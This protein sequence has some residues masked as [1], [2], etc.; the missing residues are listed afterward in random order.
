M[1]KHFWFSASAEYNPNEI[2]GH[3]FQKRWIVH[4]CLSRKDWLGIL[5]K[6]HSVNYDKWHTVI[7]IYI[8]CD[9]N[10]ML[11][12]T[13]LWLIHYNCKRSELTV[14]AQISQDHIATA[15]HFLISNFGAGKEVF[16]F[17]YIAKKQGESVLIKR[18]HSSKP[19][20]LNKNQELTS[21]LASVIVTSF[22]SCI[23]LMV[24]ESTLFC[25][26]WDG[27]IWFLID[28]WVYSKQA[29]EYFTRSGGPSCQTSFPFLTSHAS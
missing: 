19:V 18:I 26:Q 17:D 1:D 9:C 25:F 14:S 27:E 7:I 3:S 20:T 12:K 23:S 16:F 15:F 2:H 29:D 5:W 11:D 22:D 13:I 4:Y 24:I 28:C 21:V 10:L 8:C 6:V